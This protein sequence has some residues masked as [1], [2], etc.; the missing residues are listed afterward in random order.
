[1]SEK[2]IKGF[3][4]EVDE[5]SEE[6]EENIVEYD[7]TSAPRDWNPS[8]IVEM[9][10]SGFMEMPLFQRNFVWD[11]KRASKFIESL[12]LGLPVP[13]LFV[14]IEDDEESTYKIIDGQQRILSIYFFIKGKFPKNNKTRSLIREKLLRENLQKENL[15]KKNLFE[16]MLNDKKLFQD[17]KLKL[18]PGSRYNNKTFNEL[19]EMKLKFRLRRYVR[20]ILIRQNKPDDNQDSMYEIFNRL[21]TGGVQLTAQEIRAS[22]YYCPFYDMMMRINCNDK[23]RQLIGND[24]LEIHSKD[25]EFI[26]R[27]FAMLE[28]WKEYSPRMLVFLNDYSHRS[29]SFESE[30]IDYLENLFYSFLDSCSW[31]GYRPFY[32]ENGRFSVSVFEAVFVAVCSKAYENHSLVEGEI[33]PNRFGM[34][35]FDERFES[36]TRANS[37][38]KE[39]ILNRIKTAMSI[40]SFD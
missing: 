14:Y 6:Q 19:D 23:W 1:M 4:I 18:A 31:L 21:N 33:D 37:T 36:Y 3:E 12:I 8:N 30:K 2:E 22:L 15:Q 7:I 28:N 20:A 35:K 25:V 10:D 16:D 24:N 17:F 34:L 5:E 38:S 40:I 11:I 29:M 27:A 9:I 26:L 32:K 39:N 13:E